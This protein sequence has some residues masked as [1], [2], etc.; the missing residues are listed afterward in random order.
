M[1]VES[2]LAA[3][4][5]DIKSFWSK[6]TSDVAKAKA[7]WAIIS[8]PQTRSVLL[9]L[10]EAAVTAVKDAATSVEAGTINITLD[11]IVVSDINTLIADAK[12][13]DA[14]IVADLK[15]IGVIL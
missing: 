13:G 1:S 2:T 8:S 7:I 3:V 14:V 5:T 12:A 9:A 15:A 10:G 11:T 4:G 6:L